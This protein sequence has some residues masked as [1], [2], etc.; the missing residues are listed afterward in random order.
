[1]VYVTKEDPNPIQSIFI[2]GTE[3]I[4]QW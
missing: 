3:L 4:E 1:M 2:S